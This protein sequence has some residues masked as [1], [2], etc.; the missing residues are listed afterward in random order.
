[1]PMNENRMNVCV[2]CGAEF[3]LT[4]SEI[5]FYQRKGLQ[6][7]RRCERCRKIKRE[8]QAR[9]DLPQSLLPPPGSRLGRLLAGAG[10]RPAADAANGPSNGAGRPFTPPPRHAAAFRRPQRTFLAHFTLCGGPAQVPFEPDG[11]R[12]I[13]CRE[14]YAGGK[15]STRPWGTRG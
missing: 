3:H 15:A 4:S 14:C 13:Y 6:S 1:M 12:P 8:R 5:D 2:E 10:P 11:V 7:P 9:Q